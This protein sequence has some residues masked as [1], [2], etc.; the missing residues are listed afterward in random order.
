[1]DRLIQHALTEAYRNILPAAVYPVVL[2]FLEMPTAEV[3]VNVHPSKTEVR[4]R[5]QQAVHDFVRDSA[6]AALL[7]ARPVP[8]FV[9]EIS[10]QPRAA[11][12]L[13]PGALP[14]A[15]VEQAAEKFLLEPPPVEPAN[16]ALQFE[17]S[18]A[19]QANAARGL[20]PAPAIAPLRA[21]A[22]PAGTCG[23]TI[24]AEDPVDDQA[25]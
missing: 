9:Q 21:P 17:G 5:Q 4:F 19:L 16:A 6:R 14:P 20:A 10:A 24:N 3:D 2:L 22:I 7:K 13:T 1:R 8:H 11:T 25:G 15:G 12:S 23:G 18:L